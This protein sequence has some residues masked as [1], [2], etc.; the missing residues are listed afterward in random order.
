MALKNQD[1]ISEFGK[2]LYMMMERYNESAED[3]KKIN[4]PK[5]LAIAF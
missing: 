4:S 5:D 2:R 3:A 1:S